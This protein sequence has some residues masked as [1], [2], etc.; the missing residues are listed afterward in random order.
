M[1]ATLLPNRQ[2]WVCLIAGFVTITV[3]I[4][5]VA[6]RTDSII[7][8]PAG[9]LQWLML[10][11]IVVT[12]VVGMRV[13]V[14]TEDSGKPARRVRRR[15]GW[16]LAFA[17]VCIGGELLVVPVCGLTRDA[18]IGSKNR[19][20]LKRIGSAILRY[21]D[22]K[23]SLPPAAIRGGDGRSLLSWRV[24]ILPYLGEDDLFARFH[25]DEPWDSANNR[26][27]LPLMPDVFRYAVV[28]Q[29]PRDQTFFQVLVGPGTAFEREGLKMPDDFPDGVSD[30]ILVVEAATA[31]RWTQP[32]DL[33]YIPDVALPEFGAVIP[34]SSYRGRNK[35]RFNVLIAD[36]AIRS[37]YS[38]LPP[39]YIR[40]WIT[41]NG[42]EKVD[43]GW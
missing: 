13:L 26:V 19:D 27:L 43:R 41:R 17:S 3:A 9:W 22:D 15:A 8:P 37:F 42:K 12:W 31:V 28:V 11:G 40:P 2:A 16:G 36:G 10:V 18:A 6:V 24:A 5:D 23:G 30:T 32:I 38:R 7:W 25:L 14:I 1:T 29:A 35:D 33:A 20:N 4:L 39:I 21:H 34:G